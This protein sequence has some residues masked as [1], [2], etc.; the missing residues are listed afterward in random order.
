MGLLIGYR[1]LALSF[2]R[3]VIGGGSIRLF[4]PQASGPPSARS[5]APADDGD[6]E[7]LDGFDRRRRRPDRAASLRRR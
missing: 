1:M 5:E 6:G 7:V 3:V 2:W 4:R